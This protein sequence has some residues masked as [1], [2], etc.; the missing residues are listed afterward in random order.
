MC[1]MLASMATL[2]FKW[3]PDGP[4]YYLD[5]EPVHAG[6]ILEARN[7][8]GT[9]TTVRFEYHWDRKKNTVQPFLILSQEPVSHDDSGVTWLENELL[10]THSEC[11]WPR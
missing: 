8:D 2:K 11:R 5:G 10:D 7:G 9:W 3:Q 6:N 1:A 4:R